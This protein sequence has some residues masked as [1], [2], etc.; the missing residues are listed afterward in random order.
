ME[1]VLRK[2]DSLIG[3]PSLTDEGSSV[4]SGLSMIPDMVSIRSWYHL[5]STNTG[6]ALGVRF[7]AGNQS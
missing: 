1:I 2:V 3:N 7:G 5:A 4:E 6:V